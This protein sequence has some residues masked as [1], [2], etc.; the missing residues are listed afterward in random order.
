MTCRLHISGVTVIALDTREIFETVAA[1]Q[2]A[3]GEPV[4]AFGFSEM[5]D[6]GYRNW[7]ACDANGEALGPGTQVRLVPHGNDAPDNAE[8][9]GTGNLYFGPPHDQD[10]D[11][12]LIG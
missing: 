5:P 6:G 12:Y 7:M 1:E 4:I 8:H 2:F 10:Y 11:L 3:L 9:I